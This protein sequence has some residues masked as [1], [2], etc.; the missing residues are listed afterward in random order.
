M[1]DTLDTARSSMDAML[2]L[3]QARWEMTEETPKRAWAMLWSAEEHILHRLTNLE[4]FCLVLDYR[5]HL[6]R[7]EEEAS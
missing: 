4:N 7:Q 2:I 1:T 3:R 5:E 6:W